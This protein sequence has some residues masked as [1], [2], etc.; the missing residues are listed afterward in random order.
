MIRVCTPDTNSGTKN[1]LYFLCWNFTNVSFSKLSPDVSIS[2][3]RALLIH[4]NLF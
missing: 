1:K 2:W 3:T 4:K